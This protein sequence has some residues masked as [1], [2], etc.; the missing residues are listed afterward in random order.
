[1]HLLLHG[2]ELYCHTIMLKCGATT[3][4]TI[5]TW[6]RIRK[7]TWRMWLLRRHRL[8]SRP[9]H[10]SHPMPAKASRPPQPLRSTLHPPLLPPQPPNPSF[11]GLAG[12]TATD[13]P[14]SAA[15]SPTSAALARSLPSPSPSKKD[16]ILAVDPDIECA[17]VE[18]QRNVRACAEQPTPI[19]PR[20][21]QH[22]RSCRARRG[23]PL[24]GISEL[25]AMRRCSSSRLARAPRRRRYS[26]IS[27]S[28]DV[29]SHS[30]C[31]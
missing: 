2:V 5:C 9:S 11:E 28:N 13:T 6:A 23:V 27:L 22:A 21:R 1:M 19:H 14:R 16:V 31:S 30:E 18:L 12:P 10:P 24:V 20:A 8:A 7:C 17:N 25:V 15:A 26:G 4:S 3:L 29:D